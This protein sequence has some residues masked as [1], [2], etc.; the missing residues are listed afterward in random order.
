MTQ[1]KS[2]TA[3]ALAPVARRSTRRIIAT[4]VPPLDQ[5]GEPLGGGGNI[6]IL[7]AT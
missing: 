1:Y 6:D 5:V 3:G 7:A 4:M 2:I